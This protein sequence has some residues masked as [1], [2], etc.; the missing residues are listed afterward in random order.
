[1]FKPL[2]IYLGL[3][4]IRSKKTKG[5]GSFISAS[6]TFGIALGVIVLIVGLS[7]MNG[8]ERALE[9]SLLSVIPHSELIGVNQPLASWQ[10]TVQQVEQHPNVIAAA[11]MIKLQGMMQKRSQLKGV[12]LRGVEPR[13]EQKVSAIPDYIIQ[14]SWQDLSKENAVVLG[15]GIAKKLAVT[16]D[17]SVQML[18]ASPRSNNNA[19]RQL[20]TL[21]KRNM[22]VVGIFKFGGEID[23]GQAYISLSQ[24]ASILNYS[25]NKAQGIRLKV[26]DIFNSPAI[27]R[28]VGRSLDEYLYLYDWTGSQGHLYNDIQL[29]RMVMFI[30]IA[31]VIAVASFNIVSTLI[32]AVNEKQS[33]IAI[34]KTMG[35]S[36]L[37]IMFSFVLQGLINGIN[38][39]I[40]GGLLGVVI[41]KN[42][43]EIIT[44]VEGWLNIHVLSG[45]VYF[46]DYIPSYV[47]QSDVV[48]TIGIALTMSILA[49]IYPALRVTKIEPA[50]V[51]GQS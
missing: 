46:I 4:Y 22:I 2:S 13:L 31:L 30:V 34:L 21:Q 23:S 50:Q 9:K 45:D 39:C 51:L 40:I 18:L 32:M 25:S 27:T 16:V 17:D 41:A 6:S 43:T 33:D 28:Q 47:Q 20:G 11:P 3:R 19:S 5:F 29:V 36:P 24:A 26:D 10:K 12:E 48:T 44:T 37:T 42:L 7:A 15:A 38:G 8:F 14:G 1:M 49:T 35:A